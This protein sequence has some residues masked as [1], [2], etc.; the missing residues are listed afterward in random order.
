MFL[1][2]GIVSTKPTKFKSAI[3]AADI[4]LALH[5]TQV[6]WKVLVIHLNHGRGT[7]GRYFGDRGG[8]GSTNT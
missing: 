5:S 2:I 1:W 4:A 8:G 3:K 7:H 6:C